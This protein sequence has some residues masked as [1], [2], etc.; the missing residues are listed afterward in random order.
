MSKGK[1]KEFVWPVCGK[2]STNNFSLGPGS[3][4]HI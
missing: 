1:S 4:R 2:N 3:A